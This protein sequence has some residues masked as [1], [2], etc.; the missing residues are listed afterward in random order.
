MISEEQFCPAFPGAM[1][2]YKM[3]FFSEPFYR[4]FFQRITKTGNDNIYTFTING[5]LF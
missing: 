1:L 4:R 5:H 3:I 2:Q